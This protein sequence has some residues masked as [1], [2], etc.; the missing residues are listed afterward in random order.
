MP[1]LVNEDTHCFYEP[2]FLLDATQQQHS[3]YFLKSH[4]IKPRKHS[5][6]ALENGKNDG[7]NVFEMRHSFL[8]RINGHMS[9]TV[10]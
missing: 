4:L 8:R 2:A 5:R 7:I 1:G 3:L 6:T 10:I 9:F